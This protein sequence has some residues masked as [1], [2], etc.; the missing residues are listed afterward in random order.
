[1]SKQREIWLRVMNGH[2]EIFYQ[3][4]KDGKNCI[5]VIEKSA[6]DELLEK[7]KEVSAALIGIEDRLDE[8]LDPCDVEVTTP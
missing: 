4:P 7:Y 6:Y 5:H 8:L 2:C 1:M 3:D